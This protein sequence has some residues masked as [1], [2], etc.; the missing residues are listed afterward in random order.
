MEPLTRV[1]EGCKKRRS[2]AVHQSE[3]HIGQ[4]KTTTDKKSLD[5]SSTSNISEAS[6]SSMLLILHCLGTKVSQFGQSK[7]FRCLRP[8][9]V[10]QMPKDKEMRLVR[11]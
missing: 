7:A 3:S 1:R 9:D 5:D 6:F 8:S 2:T 10:K 4:M 11:P